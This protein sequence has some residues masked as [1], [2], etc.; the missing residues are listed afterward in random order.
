MRRQKRAARYGLPFL[1]SFFDIVGGLLCCRVERYQLNVGRR[2]VVE[3]ADDDVVVCIRRECLGLQV[4]LV[5][6]VQLLVVDLCAYGAEKAVEH[7][8][9]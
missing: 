9:L 6:I 8:L 1:V 7:L 4:C 5:A 2:T 3:S